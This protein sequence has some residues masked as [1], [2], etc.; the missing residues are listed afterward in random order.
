M[1]GYTPFLITE[2]YMSNRSNYGNVTLKGI[3]PA[4]VAD[5]TE[6]VQQVVPLD[7]VAVNAAMDDL[8]SFGDTLRTVIKPD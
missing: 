8:E 1:V 4:R 2:A 5:V 6:I 3:D 7:A